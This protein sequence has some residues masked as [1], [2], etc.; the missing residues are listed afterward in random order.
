MAKI[1][2]KAGKGAVKIIGLFAILGS[3]NAKK[4]IFSLNRSSKML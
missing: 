2:L 1:I 3:R 4:R